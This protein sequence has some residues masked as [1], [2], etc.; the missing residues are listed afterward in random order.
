MYFG[1]LGVDSVIPFLEFSMFL[2]VFLGSS[3]FHCLQSYESFGVRGVMS[4]VLGLGG[5]LSVS[6]VLSVLDALSV[7][8]MFLVFQAL[9]PF[10]LSSN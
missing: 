8:G 3:C 1:A 7:L 6:G 4:D 2:G 5:V 9:V 10:V